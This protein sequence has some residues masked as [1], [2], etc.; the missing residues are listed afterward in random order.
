MK[1]NDWIGVSFSM[2]LHALL[3]LVF[4]FT[5]PDVSEAETPVGYIEV[6]FGAFEEGRPTQRAPQRQP[7][8]E[9]VPDNPE[10]EPEPEPPQSPPEQPDPEVETDPEP[11]AAQDPVEVQEQ[12]E[13]SEEVIE[14]NEPVDVT[15]EPQ[16]EPQ[17]DNAATETAEE[18]IRPLGSGT[19]EGETGATDAEE[20]EGADQ[21]KA[22]PFDIEGLN[23]T[24]VST[25]LPAYAANV[26]ATISFRITVSPAG[27]VIR[28][29]PI[30]KANAALERAVANALDRWRFNP[31]PPNA[32]Q[33]NQSGIVT[34]RFRLE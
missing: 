28:K 5:T 3:L 25:P 30:R 21:R 12:P 32:P 6:E 27:Q 17:N 14:V 15:P 4:W 26:N 2:G 24:P 8:P 34:F 23:R 29:L 13:V 16:T 22:A 33:E 1:K 11:E 7:E 31:L 20:G 10:P 9:P 18:V 19:P